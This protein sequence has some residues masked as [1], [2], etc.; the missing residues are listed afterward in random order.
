MAFLGSA[1]AALFM[2]TTW[3]SRGALACFWMSVRRTL[4]GGNSALSYV[5]A[6]YVAPF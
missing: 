1:L 6:F 2:E 5:N 4:D 3:C